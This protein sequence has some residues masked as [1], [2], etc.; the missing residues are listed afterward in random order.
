MGG[1]TALLDGVCD[2]LFYALKKDRDWAM[3]GIK[4][5]RPGLKD[6]V[7]ELVKKADSEAVQ[8][9]VFKCGIAFR[10]FLAT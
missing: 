2:A 6:H 7:V 5:N 9:L 3:S 8:S 4:D 1:L 10:A